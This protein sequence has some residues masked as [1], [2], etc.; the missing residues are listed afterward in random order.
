MYVLFR[1]WGSTVAE[2]ENGS[3]FG[4]LFAFEGLCLRNIPSVL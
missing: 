1:G 4:I 3:A 2:T